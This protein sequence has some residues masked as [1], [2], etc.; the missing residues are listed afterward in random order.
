MSISITESIV[1]RRKPEDV[2]DFTTG[3]RAAR[4]VGRHDP[5][6]GGARGG[7]RPRVRV[8]AK[9]GLR[10][11]FG[12][13]TIGAAA[14]DERRDDRGRVG[15]RR[16]GGGSWSYEPCD[17]GTRWTQTNSGAP[18]EP[19]C[20]VA[21]RT[22]APLDDAARS[23]ARDEEGENWVGGSARH[24]DA[25]SLRRSGL[26]ARRAIGRIVGE[27]WRDRRRSQGGARRATRAPRRSLRVLSSGEFP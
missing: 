8:R 14:A 3:L 2:W 10:G 16:G 6:G 24:R 17:G 11:I 19:V 15:A 20:R 7:A 27:Q 9:G 5:R 22:L 25:D 1:I 21:A 4:R 18:E 13:Q 26:R 12:I 23:A